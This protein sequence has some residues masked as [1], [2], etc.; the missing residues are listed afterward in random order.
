MVFFFGF[1]LT[2]E[3]Y[4]KYN[5]L[6]FS[7]NQENGNDRKLLFHQ[8]LKCFMRNLHANICSTNYQ[9][10]T[11]INSLLLLLLMTVN[12]NQQSGHTRKL[13]SNREIFTIT[14]T[15]VCARECAGI[16]QLPENN[17]NVTK[18]KV[19]TKIRTKT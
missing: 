3:A 7:G 17:P 13:L 14:S 8:F 16:C 12:V 2:G 4:D 1:P 6:L 18:I 15:H 9:T 5:I 19:T 11:W 10:H